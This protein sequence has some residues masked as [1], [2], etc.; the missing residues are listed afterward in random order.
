MRQSSRGNTSAGTRPIATI[1]RGLVPIPRSSQP[2]LG[3]CAFAENPDFDARQ[4][5]PCWR[6]D[7]K[8]VC[9][10]PTERTPSILTFSLWRIPGRKRLLHDGHRLALI[11][12][13]DETPLRLSLAPTLA[14]ETPFAISVPARSDVTEP[15]LTVRRLITDLTGSVYPTN[16][17]ATCRPTRLLLTHMRA[18]QALDASIAGAS[19]RDIAEAIFGPKAVTSRWHPDSELRAQV[20]HLIRRARALMNGGYRTLLT[21]ASKGRSPTPKRISLHKS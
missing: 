12:R 21:A 9:V 3:G 4:A 14:D 13:Y 10:D 18:L 8:C 19:H 17:R 5:Q 2:T 1:G 16:Q 6:E 15:W 20:R 7:K 11:A